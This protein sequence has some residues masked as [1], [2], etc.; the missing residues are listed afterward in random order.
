MMRE[1]SDDGLALVLDELHRTVARGRYPWDAWGDAAAMSEHFKVWR[2]GRD[3]ELPPEQLAVN[4][5]TMIK[6]L[7]Q[8][9]A[10]RFADRAQESAQ[11]GYA[12]A[13]RATYALL[14]DICHPSGGTG[15]L[16]LSEG[17]S[18]GWIKVNATTPADATR[19][20]FSGPIGPL[21]LVPSIAMLALDAL[22]QLGGE[23]FELLGGEA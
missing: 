6:T 22:N 17:R 10:H 12:G 13:V 1:R 19:W 16:L 23:G 11:R 8:E 4:V 3:P 9:F 18:V 7:D 15:L 5:L 14:S 2:E 20:L 21:L